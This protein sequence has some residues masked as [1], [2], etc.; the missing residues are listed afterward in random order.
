VPRASEEQDGGSQRRDGIALDGYTDPR[1]AHAPEPRPAGRF[2]ALQG[3]DAEDATTDTSEAEADWTDDDPWFDDVRSESRRGDADA[4]LDD[5]AGWPEAEDEDDQI[6]TEEDD[7]ELTLEAPLQDGRRPSPAARRRPA[8]M[9]EDEIIEEPPGDEGH[10]RRRPGGGRQR[11]GPMPEG[12][13][14]VTRRA[15]FDDQDFDAPEIEL[16]GRREARSRPRPAAADEDDF[17]TG[18]PRQGRPPRAGRRAPRSGPGGRVAVDPPG[19]EPGRFART[20]ATVAN[21]PPPSGPKP[22]PDRPNR[23]S[24]PPR[25]DAP[26]R[27]TAGRRRAP[28]ASFADSMPFMGRARPSPVEL[29]RRRRRRLI[30]APLILAIAA[31]G[32]WYFYGEQGGLGFDLDQTVARVGSSIGGVA[33]SVQGLDLGNTVD[34]SGLLGQGDS[35]EPAAGGALPTDGQH[36]PATTGELIL[37]AD[38]PVGDDASVQDL[39]PPAAAQDSPPPLVQPAEPGGLSGLP[40][41][42]ETTAAALPDTA[43][44]G[45]AAAAAAPLP[46]P[47]PA[48]KPRRSLAAVNTPSPVLKPSPET[49]LAGSDLEQREAEEPSLI[50]RLW[51]YLTPG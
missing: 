50:T 41:A 2:A 3:S 39:P 33:E 47:I 12:R 18:D 43:L 16:A 31:G 37:G 9:P 25:V 46:A 48:A 17:Y 32:F 7:A 35:P 19:G 14:T 1:A 8:R 5:E 24:P 49:R 15:A 29:R 22:Q 30:A 26:A 28:K 23:A 51:R 13:R 10:A 40:A 27:G 11:P 45:Q 42:A 4:W 21:A 36:L 38:Q 44:P 20:R 34:L 6:W